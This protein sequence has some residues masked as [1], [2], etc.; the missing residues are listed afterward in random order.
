MFNILPRRF[1]REL[2]NESIRGNVESK[3]CES[4]FAKMG[5][6]VEETERCL[7][8]AW[9]TP[10]SSRWG[11]ESHRSRRSFWGRVKIHPTEYSVASLTN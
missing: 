6:I 9:R 7:W 5:G 2:G 11:T 3:N 1:E 4:G 8:I 10:L